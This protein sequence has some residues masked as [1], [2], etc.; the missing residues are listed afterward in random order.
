M[1]WLVAEKGASLACLGP[2]ESNEE[3]AKSVALAQ[4]EANPG[5]V[6]QV[7]YHVNANAPAEVRWEALN[8]Q[9]IEVTHGERVTPSEHRIGVRHF[10][11]F[12]AHIEPPDGGKR[13]AMIHDLSVSGALLVVRAPL[14]VGETDALPYGPSVELLRSMLKSG[15]FP[16][17]LPVS[18][19]DRLDAAVYFQVSLTPTALVEAAVPLEGQPVFAVLVQHIPDVAKGQRRI[20]IRISLYR[21]GTPG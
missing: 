6:F 14:A 13:T 16:T 19:A 10:A 9:I 1:G 12:P 7:R 18:R 17:E 15:A 2:T 5:F 11:C 3:A 20:I 8:G 4:S 21:D